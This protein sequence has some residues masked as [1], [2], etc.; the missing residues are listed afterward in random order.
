L[1]QGDEW[2]PLGFQGKS[3][4]IAPYDGYTKPSTIKLN[5]ILMWIQIHDLPDGFKNMV[6]TLAGKVGEYVAQ[7]T[8]SMGI[9][10]EIFI[11]LQS[12]LT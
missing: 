6:K 11:E 7:D 9:L 8:P 2:R 4:L 5:T 1:G 3:V 12:D 10:L